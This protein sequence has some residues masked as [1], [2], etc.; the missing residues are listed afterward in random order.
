MNIID[1]ANTF[2]ATDDVLDLYFIVT[3][4]AEQ[5]DLSPYEAEAH[6]V[7]DAASTNRHYSGSS[8]LHQHGDMSRSAPIGKRVE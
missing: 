1:W 2:F 7:G 4:L 3:D 5:F 8:G 6:Y